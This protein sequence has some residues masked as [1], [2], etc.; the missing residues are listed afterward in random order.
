MIQKVAELC[1]GVRTGVAGLTAAPLLTGFFFNKC[2]SILYKIANIFTFH[3]NKVKP[4][5]IL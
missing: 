2:I 4:V 1:I 5:L 3:M